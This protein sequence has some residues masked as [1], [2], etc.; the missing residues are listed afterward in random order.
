MKVSMSVGADR[1]VVQ[2]AA[3]GN[4]LDVDHPLVGSLQ[5][6]AVQ[7]VRGHLMIWQMRRLTGTAGTAHGEKV[8]VCD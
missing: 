8:Q 2:C 3:R 4:R 1:P 5:A 7:E 6:L